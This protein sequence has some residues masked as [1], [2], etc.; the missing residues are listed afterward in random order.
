[1]CFINYVKA[2]YPLLWVKSYEEHR[3]LLQYASQLSGYTVKDSRGV[4]LKYGLHTWDIS[5]GVRALPFNNGALAVGSKIENTAGDPLPALAW[6][7]EQAPDYSILFLKDYTPYLQKEFQ[8]SVVV[9]RKIR[10]L[11]A[12]FKAQGKVL[13]ILSPTVS[14]PTDLDKEVSV[15]DFKL[16]TKDDLRLVLRG[17]CV[18]SGATYPRNDEPII[19]AA[20]GMT[21]FEAENS[22]SISLVEARRFDQKVIQREKSSVVKKTGLLEIID[23]DCTLDDIGG[24]E[25]LKAWLIARKSSFTAQ[26]REFGV[27]SPKGL[28]MVGVPGCGK[29]LTAKAVGSAWELPVLRLDMG[30]IYGS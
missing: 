23:T 14:I 13:V 15:V 12:K 4:D 11:I 7:D 18:S 3:V 5:E 19:N 30:R 16:P 22:F 20:L 1:M 8:A 26:A 2:G 6:L 24:L 9:I 21:S 25:N 10:N 17:I 29:S 28:L 27:S